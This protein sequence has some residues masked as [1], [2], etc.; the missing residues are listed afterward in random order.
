MV[1]S[2]RTGMGNVSP[3][4]GALAQKSVCRGCARLAAYTVCRTSTESAKA[5]GLRFVKATRTVTA[6]PCRM[7]VGSGVVSRAWP[8]GKVI[9]ARAGRTSG[10]SVGRFSSINASLLAWLISGRASRRSAGFTVISKRFSPLTSPAL[11]SNSRS[12]SRFA[13][14]RGHVKL[15]TPQ[16]RPFTNRRI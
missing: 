4:A 6:S 15:Y 13:T 5:T 16:A 9:L 14:V 2:I 11:G 12:V 8:S 3:G 7:S 10:A 1:V